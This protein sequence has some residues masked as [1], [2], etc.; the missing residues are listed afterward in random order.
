MMQQVNLYQPILRRE[1]KVFSAITMLWMLLVVAALMLLVHAFS[2]WQLA[3]L[4]HENVRLHVQ[5][6]ELAAQ[7]ATLS[8]NLG[9]RA[10]SRER[11]REAE[12]VQHELRLKRELLARM[13]DRATSPAAGFSESF[14]AL[15]RQQVHGLWL[16]NVELHNDDSGR[17][18]AL[19]GMTLHA[20][21]VPQLVRQLGEEAAFRG[22]RFR[23]LRVF[24]PANAER[25]VLAFELSTAETQP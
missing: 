16:T 5:Q 4:E 24:Q 3:A 23:Q 14:A 21:F 9:V 13:H 19:R 18:V 20:Q 7:V 17:H 1:K 10:E 25:E 11:R 6:R 8:R 12:A 15:A 22:L 2:R